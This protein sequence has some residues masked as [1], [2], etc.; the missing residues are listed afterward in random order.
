MEELTAYEMLDL[1]M[2]HINAS[3]DDLNRLLAIGS[4]Y[5]VCAY[6]AGKELTRFQVTV[7]N[8]GFVIFS[9][10]A[11]V[12][13]IG[14]YSAAGIYYAAVSND[15]WSQL[16][17]DNNTEWVRYAS[18]LFAGGAILGCLSFMWSVRHPKEK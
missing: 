3:V 15:A 11:L 8:I 9:A 17:S 5:L 4:A 16:N 12:G 1:A 10:Q 2:G 6:K 14:E 18:G 7:I 13:V